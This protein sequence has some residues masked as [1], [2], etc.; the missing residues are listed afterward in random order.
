MRCSRAFAVRTLATSL[1]ISA[2]RKRD[3]MDSR[4]RPSLAACVMSRG[5]AMPCAVRGLPSLQLA[6][7]EGSVPCVYLTARWRV[8][9]SLLN[10]YIQEWR[11]VRPNTDPAL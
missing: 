9:L 4:R 2:A 3:G 11:E 8:D 7:Q 10:T 5:N 6:I 1:A